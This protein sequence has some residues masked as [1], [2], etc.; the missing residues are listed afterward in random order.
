VQKRTEFNTDGFEA[1]VT[2]TV[3]DSAGNVI[4]EDEFYSKYKTVDGI[5]QV[6]RYPGDPPDGT[7]I[8]RSEFHPHNAPPPEG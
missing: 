1:W 2:R 5:T 7:T 4:H 8:P 6:G 3:K